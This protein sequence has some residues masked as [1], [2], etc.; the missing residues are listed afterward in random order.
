M[1]TK[2]CKIVQKYA[3]SIHFTKSTIPQTFLNLQKN[4]SK[5]EKFLLHFSTQSSTPLFIKNAIPG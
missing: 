1:C 4:H 2:L 5:L 3:K